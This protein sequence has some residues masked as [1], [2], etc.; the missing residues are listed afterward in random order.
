MADEANGSAL[1]KTLRALLLVNLEP[2]KQKQQIAILDQAGFGRTE[3]AGIVGST[4]N[5]VGVRLAEIKKD[6]R[7]NQKK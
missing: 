2:L 6:K 1:E 5:A 7:K 3:I 4:P